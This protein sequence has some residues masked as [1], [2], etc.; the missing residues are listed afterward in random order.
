MVDLHSR[1]WT[2]PN[3]L[4]MFLGMFEKVRK[5]LTL[6]NLVRIDFLKGIFKL[7]SLWMK[8]GTYNQN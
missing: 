4:K 6:T 7:N 2:N 1:F 3:W 5:L 8:F